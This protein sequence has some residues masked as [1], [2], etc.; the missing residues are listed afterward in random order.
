MPIKAEFYKGKRRQNMAEIWF[1][2]IE[3]F[4]YTLQCIGN[5]EKEVLDAMI[6]EYIK[7]YKKRNGVDPSVEEDADDKEYY[8]V[9]LEELCI[10]KRELGKVEWT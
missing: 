4:G 9:F 6:D 8:E 10:E 2:E 3:R 5:S 1:S 7:T